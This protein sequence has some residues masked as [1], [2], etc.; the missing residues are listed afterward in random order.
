MGILLEDIPQSPIKV[1]VQTQANI[2]KMVQPLFFQ[3]KSNK[4]GYQRRIIPQFLINLSTELCLLM[5]SGKMVVIRAALLFV[6]EK[7]L[8][9]SPLITK[10]TIN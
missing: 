4:F 1:L 6:Q 2:S 9:T 7:T 3:F 8:I 5:L 10:A